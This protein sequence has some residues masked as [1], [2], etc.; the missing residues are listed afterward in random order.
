MGIDVHTGKEAQDRMQDRLQEVGGPPVQDVKHTLPPLFANDGRRSVWPGV[1]SFCVVIALAVAAWF[2]LSWW[3][4]R[5]I[6]VAAF[7]PEDVSLAVFLPESDATITVLSAVPHVQAYAAQLAQPYGFSQEDIAQIAQHE[8]AIAHRGAGRTEAV[9]I[10]IRRSDV[11]DA[12]FEQRMAS[13]RVHEDRSVSALVAAADGVPREIVSESGDVMYVMAHRRAWVLSND[14]EV[15]REMVASARG[16]QRALS[17]D[18]LMRT[19]SDVLDVRSVPTLYST[20]VAS[21]ARWQPLWDEVFGSASLVAL[22]L[23]STEPEF[24]LGVSRSALSEADRVGWD[25]QMVV[26][27][28]AKNMSIA[29]LLEYVAPDAQLV[30]TIVEPED[31]SPLSAVATSSIRSATAALLERTTQ[32]IDTA[33]VIELPH[34]MDSTSAALPED[35]NS[36]EHSAVAVGPGSAQLPTWTGWTPY[37]WSKRT[38]KP[39]VLTQQDGALVLIAR[40]EA[41]SRPGVIAQFESDLLYGYATAFPSLAPLEREDG[42]EGQQ[43]VPHEE[44]FVMQ[45]QIV[46]GQSLRVVATTNAFSLSVPTDRP[47]LLSNDERPVGFGYTTIGDV[48]IASVSPSAVASAVEHAARSDSYTYA[49]TVRAFSDGASP[50]GVFESCIVVDPYAPSLLRVVESLRGSVVLRHIRVDQTCSGS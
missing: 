22:S 14:I 50:T 11:V 30:T 47:Q 16:D 37:E 35:R 10:V 32:E 15:V 27:R 19:A 40:L 8:L 49:D 45:D 4:S 41:S 7:L 3:T 18:A 2:G 34:G 29:P 23:I 43:Y 42:S 33:S 17:D 31:A 24:V 26:P 28:V 21:R 39:V 6:S 25:V 5:T 12:I 46:N 36:A 13:I 9:M 20:S 38:R 44:A 48:L 1:F